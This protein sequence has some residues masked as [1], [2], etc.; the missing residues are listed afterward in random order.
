MHGPLP[1]DVTLDVPHWW[2]PG[3]PLLPLADY[4]TPVPLQR[5]RRMARST[6]V[7]VRVSNFFCGCFFKWWRLASFEFF[8]RGAAPSGLS[9]KE[10][11]FIGRERVVWSCAS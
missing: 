6:G 5:D 1:P 8:R 11:L 4:M 9:R 3:M 7:S 10:G 2:Q